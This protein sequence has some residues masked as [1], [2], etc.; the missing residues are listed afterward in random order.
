LQQVFINLIAN[1]REAM[2]AKDGERRLTVSTRKSTD[3]IYIELEDTGIGADAETVS[4]MFLPFFTTKTEGKGTGLGLSI[5]DRIIMEHGGRIDVQCA[6]G[7]GC[8]FTIRLPSGAGN[9]GET[10]K[11]RIGE[12]KKG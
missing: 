3:G 11:G 5:V 9:E 7:E 10:A 6:P 2:D 12:K 4:R 8:K 1:A